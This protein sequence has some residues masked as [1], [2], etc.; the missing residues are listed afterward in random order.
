[1]KTKKAMINKGNEKKKKELNINVNSLFN[2]MHE[3]INMHVYI[4]KILLERNNYASYCFT[5][6]ISCKDI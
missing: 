1:M 2:V 6:T 4:M 5:A 3:R